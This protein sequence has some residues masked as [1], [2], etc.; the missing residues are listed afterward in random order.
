MTLLETPGPLAEIRTTLLDPP[1]E[2]LL[3]LQRENLRLR[4]LVGELLVKNQQLR[5]NGLDMHQAI[6]L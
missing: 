2:L 3:D 6:R 5:S 1:S 4:S